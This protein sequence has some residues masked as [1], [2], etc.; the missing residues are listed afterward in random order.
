[1]G[2]RRFTPC[3]TSQKSSGVNPEHAFF[4]PKLSSAF[5]HRRFRAPNLILRISQRV[6]DVRSLLLCSLSDV[7]LQTCQPLTF[8]TIRLTPI[9][10]LT[11]KSTVGNFPLPPSLSLYPTNSIPHTHQSPPAMY[12]AYPHLTSPLP[13]PPF[14]SPR[15]I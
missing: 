3:Q 13:S 8:S 10:C 11:G 9:P 6:R 7:A 4:F 1:M 15:P 2:N 5:R 14:P 12:L